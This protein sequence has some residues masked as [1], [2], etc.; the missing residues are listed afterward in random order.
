MRLGDGGS[1]STVRSVHTDVV[2]IQGEHAPSFVVNMVA[3]ADGAIKRVSV[4][5]NKL[6][7]PRSE[8]GMWRGSDAASPGYG[9]GIHL[10]IFTVFLARHA[11]SADATPSDMD[12]L[13]APID[14][15]PVGVSNLFAPYGLNAARAALCRISAQEEESREEA[16]RV[17]RQ[18]AATLTCMYQCGIT[19]RDGR[20]LSDARAALR[21]SVD[22]KL[23][24]P[25]LGKR[26][27]GLWRRRAAERAYHPE[28]VRAAM[29]AEFHELHGLKRPPGAS[30]PS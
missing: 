15:R 2:L 26:F 27:G 29:L 1:C 13:I 20:L 3:A 6:H 10:D 21:E 18:I 17:V 28:R 8:G 25:L 23:R 4:R 11:A 16:Q 19:V 7:V 12:Y 22:C 30:L 24:A 9:I 5:I 14:G